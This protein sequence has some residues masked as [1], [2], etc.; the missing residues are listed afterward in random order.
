MTKNITIQRVFRRSTYKTGKQINE[1]D[2]EKE[3][4]L[5]K[6]IHTLSQI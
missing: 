3:K 5:N 2:L 1:K 6:P 4:Y